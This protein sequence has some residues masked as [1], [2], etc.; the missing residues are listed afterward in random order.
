MDADMAIK[1]KLKEPE[2]L[3]AFASANI[4]TAADLQKKSGL[5]RS[6]SQAAFRGDPVSRTTAVYVVNAINKNGGSATFTS[7]FAE[8]AL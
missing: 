5:S 3:D 4:A 1:Y 8:V 6:T 2:G 7:I